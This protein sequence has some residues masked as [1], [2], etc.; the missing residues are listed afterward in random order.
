MPRKKK[1]KSAHSATKQKRKSSRAK[2]K[3][4]RKPSA[5]KTA[6]KKKKA[7]PEV[8]P[9]LNAEKLKELYA[10]MVK[11]RM[12]AE[13]VQSER[14]ANNS[15][16]GFEATLVGAGAHLLPRDCIAMEHSSF[17]ASLIKG[18]P[19]HS[20]LARNR[21]HQSGNGTGGAVSSKHDGNASLALSMETIL[22][23]AAEMNGKG[24]VTL[25]FCTKNPETLIF[26]P[27]AMAVAAKQKL[28]LVCLVESSLD[29]PL[30]LPNQVASGPYIGADAT[31]YPRIPVDGCDVVGVFRVAQEAIRRAREGHGPA[32]IECLTARSG[33]KNDDKQTSSHYLAQ[34]PI[35]FMEQ[36][37][38][39]RKLWS[40][41]W[42]RSVS[43]GFD[44]EMKQAAAS[45]EHPADI[46]GQFDNVYSSD[47]RT[48]R[49]AAASAR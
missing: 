28:P 44:Q 11:C 25:M 3:P 38:R 35:S 18:T 7:E 19:L 17:V 20:I 13:R 4:A 1:K 34:D 47:V 8:L 46:E 12:L 48:P 36:Y 37:L 40:D 29:S 45:L 39:R 22:A 21:A 6:A 30:Q 43:V 41:E 49:P 14:I 23:L 15:V 5:K 33:A 27:A 32:V 42:S 2:T 10:T 9:V 31:F 24:A 16:L 26:D